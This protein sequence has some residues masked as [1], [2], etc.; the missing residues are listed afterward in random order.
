MESLLIG[1]FP[2]LVEGQAF[3]PLLRLC[4]ITWI[5]RMNNPHRNKKMRF[6]V[7]GKILS[8]AVLLILLMS[9]GC[10]TPK[11]VA[12]FQ[13]V[14]QT[15]LPVEKSRPIRIEPSNRLSII[16]KSK[17]PELSNL[18]NLPV[19]SNRLGEAAGQYSSD[20]MSVYTVDAEGK[21]D[22]PVLGDLKVEGMTRGELASFIKGELIGK[23]LVKDPVVTV[24]LLDASFSVMGEVNR[25]G[26]FPIDKDRLN[27]LEALSIAGDLTIQGRRENII[28]AREEA[29]GVHTYRLDLTNMNE[30]LSS[31]AYYVKQGDVVYVEPNDVRKR[32]TTV[33]GNNLLSWS[34]WVSVASLLTS[35][36]VLI[37]K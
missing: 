26:R 20:G 25:P 30:L 33:N 24:E 10:S 12:Y 35:I 27:I 22:F 37:V 16:V 28:V 32:Q 21:I 1:C 3:E 7:K 11:D 14:S 4:G 5:P 13:D 34:F 15:V 2:S 18:Y 9:V 31:P 8:I 17:D 6:E 19:S 29:D 23:G 36:A